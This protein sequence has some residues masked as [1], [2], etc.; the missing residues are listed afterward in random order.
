GQ[1]A[2]HGFDADYILG[3]NGNLYRLVVSPTGPFL[4]FNY[5]TSPDIGSDP[6]APFAPQTRGPR[7]V[8]PRAFTL[9]DYVPGSDADARVIGASDLI[10]GE[11][12][13]DVIHGMRGNDVLYADAWD[14]DI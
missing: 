13:D 3:D 5:D 11:D 8:I 9:L 14:D 2:D 12:G 4:T 1:V 6:N 7:R 10:H